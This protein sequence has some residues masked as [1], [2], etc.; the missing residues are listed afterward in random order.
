MTL[1]IY[2]NAGKIYSQITGNYLVP[3]GGVQYLETEVPSGKLVTGVDVS[4]TP[5]QAILADI[6]PSEIDQLRIEMAQ[7]N[8]ELFEMMLMM[9]GGAL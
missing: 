1:I 2:D 5:H 3:Q 6:P 4:V 7:A 8:T 9:N